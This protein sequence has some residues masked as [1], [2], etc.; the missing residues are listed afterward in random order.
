MTSDLRLNSTSTAWLDL[1]WQVTDETEVGD[2]HANV[3]VTWNL[4]GQ[5]EDQPYWACGFYGVKVTQDDRAPS[6][7]SC[8]VAVEDTTWETGAQVGPLEGELAAPDVLCTTLCGTAEISLSLRDYQEVLPYRFFNSSAGDVAHF[9]VMAGGFA[10]SRFTAEVDVEGPVVHTQQG[11]FE[12][13]YTYTPEDFASTL[14]ARAD[15]PL[16]APHAQFDAHHDTREVSPDPEGLVYFNPYDIDDPPRPYREAYVERPDGSRA[17]A[18]IG[19]WEA[20][21]QHGE[22]SFWYNASLRE[23]TDIPILVGTDMRW[24]EV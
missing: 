11:P 9:V 4:D 13:T 14:F 23:W 19:F 8:T 2:I 20:P 12:D 22:W 15:T 3:S 18:D 16:Y 21:I 10:P 17:S 1:A 24:A 7:I 5:A 6:A